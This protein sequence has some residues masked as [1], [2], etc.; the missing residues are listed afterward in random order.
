M[1]ALARLIM[2][3]HRVHDRALMH[4]LKPLLAR[5]GRNVKFC[6]LSSSLSYE[7]IEVGN[8]V[9]IGPGA[10]FSAVGTSIRIGDKVMF[11]PNVIIMA[12]DH[13][14]SVVG[15]FMFDVH[16]KRP[17]DDLPVVIDED[18]WVGARA[19]ILKGVHIHRGAIVAAGAV[20]TRDVPPYAIAGGVPA[21]VLKFRWPI[22]DLLQHEQALYPPDRRIDEQVLRK[23]ISDWELSR[24]SR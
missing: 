19:T 6:P 5:C 2:L 18:V 9:F 15:K 7:T 3:A 13:N 17:G 4:L 10:V 16:E 14:T 12:G 24:L 8:D 1:R 11:G 20:V 22:E 23:H 21:R